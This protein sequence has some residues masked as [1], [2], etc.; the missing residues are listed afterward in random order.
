LNVD[1][2]RNAPPE[3]LSEAPDDDLQELAGRI[4]DHIR[5]RL[6]TEL[7]IERER[8]GLLADRY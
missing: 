6:R 8:A 1:G 3:R 5:S 2:L 7:L 4:Y